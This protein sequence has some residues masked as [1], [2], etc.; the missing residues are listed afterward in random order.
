MK[1]FKFQ[2]KAKFLFGA[3]SVHVLGDEAKALGAKSVTIVTDKGIVAAG[4][5]DAVTDPLKKAGIAYTIYDD[6]PPNPTDDVIMNGAKHVKAAGSDAVIGF[7]GGSPIDAAKGIAVMATNGGA[8]DDYCDGFDPWHVPPLPIIGIPTTAGTGAEVSAAAMVNI[9]SQG[10]KKALFGPSILPVVAIADP[11]L[12]VG[13]P[14]R[15]TALTGIDALS[16]AVE[17]YVCAR[18]N[19]ISDAIAERAI[20]LVAGSLRQA[21]TNGNNLE[22]RGDMLLGSA[23]AVMAASNAGGLGVIHSLAQTLGGFY[24]LAHGLTIAVCFPYGL[25]FNAISMPEKHAAMAELMG[26]DVSDLSLF[27]AA[28][29]VVPAYQILMDDVEIIDTFETMGVKE[30]DIPRLAELAMLDG[31][32]PVNPRQLSTNIFVDLFQQ[33]YDEVALW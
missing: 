32:T 12:T 17:A 9:P 7:G 15:L 10:M 4:L 19:P 2:S 14:P 27:D 11:V 6:I 3:D 25:A 30:S 20:S 16:H 1:S 33:A 18:A 5:M 29:A 13:L 21:Y 23:M 8:V 26:F 24:N 31:S 28:K 22:A